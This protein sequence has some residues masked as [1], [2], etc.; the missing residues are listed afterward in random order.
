MNLVGKVKIVVNVLNSR[1]YQQIHLSVC[2]RPI[3]PHFPLIISLI[4]YHH[5]PESHV[6]LSIDLENKFEKRNALYMGPTEL[7][8]GN[9]KRGKKDF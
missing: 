2:L 9:K 7:N 4:S 6:Y 3:P 1:R 5:W 8:L